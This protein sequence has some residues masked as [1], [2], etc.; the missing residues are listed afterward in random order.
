MDSLSETM[1]E[2]V[3]DVKKLRQDIDNFIA[4][5]KSIIEDIESNKI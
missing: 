5:A 3:E 4:I 2:I 1:N